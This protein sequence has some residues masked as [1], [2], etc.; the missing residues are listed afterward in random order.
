MRLIR[1]FRLQLCEHLGGALRAVGDEDFPVAGWAAIEECADHERTGER[2]RSDRVK[3]PLP[4]VGRLPIF[5]LC[6]KRLAGPQSYPAQDGQDPASHVRESADGAP[7][8]MVVHRSSPSG[9]K[10]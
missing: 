1:S 4:G 8:E 10:R 5:L 6:R 2:S 3:I 7:R 9:R